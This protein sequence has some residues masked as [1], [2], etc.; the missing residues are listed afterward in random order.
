LLIQNEFVEA[1]NP[2]KDID[3]FNDWFY[4]KFVPILGDYAEREANYV[5]SSFGMSQDFTV[6]KRYLDPGDVLGQ[7]EFFIL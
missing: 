2:L 4:N 1:P 6:A 3:A 7:P 5:T